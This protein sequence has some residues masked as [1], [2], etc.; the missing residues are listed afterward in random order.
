L[1]IDITWV[2]DHETKEMVMLYLIIKVF[3]IEEGKPKKISYSS[4]TDAFLFQ[5]Q[6]D[7]YFLV[8]EVESSAGSHILQGFNFHMEVEWG[9]GCDLIR[10]LL[11]DRLTRMVVGKEFEL[12]IEK[13]KVEFYGILL[14]IL[15]SMHVTSFAYDEYHGCI[16]LGCHQGSVLRLFYNID[17]PD[18]AKTNNLSQ[19]EE[20]ETVDTIV[21][22]YKNAT[23]KLLWCLDVSEFNFIRHYLLESLK[24]LHRSILVKKCVQIYHPVSRL[25]GQVQCPQSFR[26]K[27]KALFRQIRIKGTALLQQIRTEQEIMAVLLFED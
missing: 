18:S 8:L 7:Q 17:E 1:I 25:V 10:Q 3:Q 20:D 27:E 5:Y 19:I 26:K 16:L 21:E 11:S 13:G 24:I 4:I 22:Q 23:I 6:P 14:I 9:V 2:Y 12:N 15:E